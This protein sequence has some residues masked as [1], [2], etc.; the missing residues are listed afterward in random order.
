MEIKEKCGRCG[1]KLCTGFHLDREKGI[2]IC[3]SCVTA[4]SVSLI[5][6]QNKEHVKAVLKALKDTVYI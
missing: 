2:G 6:N 3:D 4:L 1:E 5:K